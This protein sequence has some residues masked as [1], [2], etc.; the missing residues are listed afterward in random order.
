MLSPIS[1][2]SL[3]ED[4]NLSDHQSGLVRVRLAL[5]NPQVEKELR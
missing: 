1:L 5:G 4:T 3:D 2:F